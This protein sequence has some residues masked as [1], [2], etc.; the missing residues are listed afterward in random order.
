VTITESALIKKKPACLD[1][2]GVEKK[3][4]PNRFR[5]KQSRA[6]RRQMQCE[7]HTPSSPTSSGP[8]IYILSVR[9]T[10]RHGEAPFSVVDANGVTG[11]MRAYGLKQAHGSTANVEAS[12]LRGQGR[13]GL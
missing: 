11:A 2:G 12:G 6:D 5:E 1:R 3:S 4:Q 10:D 13:H 8:Q 9:S 7:A